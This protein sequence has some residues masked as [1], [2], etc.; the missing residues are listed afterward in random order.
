MM[1]DVLDDHDIAVSLKEFVGLTASLR[2]TAVSVNPV[3][4]LLSHPC[5]LCLSCRPLYDININPP[6]I[7]GYEKNPG[8][9]LHKVRKQIE[10]SFF[11]QPTP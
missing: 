11:H 6:P 1:E 5:D 2:G 4:P 9:P 3:L 7:N 10:T 8:R